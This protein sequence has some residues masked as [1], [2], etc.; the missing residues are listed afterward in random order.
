ML[1]SI[2]KKGGNKLILKLENSLDKSEFA[3]I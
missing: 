1:E 2:N 3:E